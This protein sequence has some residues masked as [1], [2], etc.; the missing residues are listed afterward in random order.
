MKPTP[1]TAACDN[2]YEPFED[3]FFL[4]DCLELEEPVL[5]GFKAPLVAEIGCGSGVVSA[6]LPSLIDLYIPMA[7]DVNPAA[8]TTTLSTWKKNSNTYNPKLPEIEVVRGSLLGFL[9]P[10]LVDV[11]VF[12]PPYVSTS[13][14]PKL[15]DY[16]QEDMRWVDFALDGGEMGMEITNIVLENLSRYLSPHGVAYILLCANNNPKQVVEN[17]EA[18]GYFAHKVSERR[19]GR[20]IL[21]VYRFSR[22]ELDQH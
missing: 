6:F 12:N 20:E 1:L 21:S 17:V 4:L 8:C 18:R 7:S 10:N 16:D 11:L 2:V 5:R 14:V 3:S 13:D 19:A 15:E 22:N 9:R